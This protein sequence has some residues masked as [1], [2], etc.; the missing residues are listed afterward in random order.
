MKDK[1]ICKHGVNVETSLICC[2]C[3]Y[4]E[5]SH[6]DH[7]ERHYDLVDELN[8]SPGYKLVKGFNMLT[9]HD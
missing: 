5:K 6:L 4:G 1:S 2:K 8:Y 7:K 3:Q 9:Q